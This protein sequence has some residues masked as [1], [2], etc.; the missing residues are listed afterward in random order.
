LQSEEDSETGVKGSENK[1][2]E[3]NSFSWPLAQ[4]GNHT[5]LQP[6]HNKDFLHIPQCPFNM[7]LH[8][9]LC[10][11]HTFTSLNVLCT[12][13]FTFFNSHISQMS[14]SNHSLSLPH[15]Y[16]PWLKFLSWKYRIH[17]WWEFFSRFIIWLTEGHHTI[18]NKVKNIFHTGI[19][20]KI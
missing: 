6:T 20:L 3:R 8:I 9:P 12:P 10:S 5:V 17:S 2:E 15:S 1:Q 4:N 11:V 19:F 16:P 14:L 18:T 13:S 7:L